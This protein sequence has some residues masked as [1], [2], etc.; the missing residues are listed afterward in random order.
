MNDGVERARAIGLDILQPSATELQ[1]GLELHEEALVFESYGFSPRAAIDGAAV[2]RLVEEGASDRELGE[3]MEE[4]GLLR[5]TEDAHLRDEYAR[6]FA[7]AGVDCV[8][9]NAGEECQSAAQLLKR[10]GNFTYLTDMLGDVMMRVPTP[11]A[12]VEA[13]RAGKRSLYMS[14]NGVPLAQEWKTAE[15][16]LRFVRV[17]FQLGVRMMHLTYNRRNMLGDGCAE[18][19]DAGLSDLGRAAIA[20]MNR[21]GVIVDVAHSGWQTCIDAAE[22]SRLPIVSSHAGVHALSGHVRCKT[23]AVMR[24]IVDKGGTLGICCVPAFLGGSGDIN[25]FLD[26]IDYVAKKFGVDAVTIGT[27]RA[28]VPPIANEEWAKV[29]KL[30]RKR[31]RFEGFW[32]PNDPLFAAEW[33]EERMQQSLAWTNWPLFTV[34]LVQRG[35][36]D[37]DICKI[38]GGNI[39][40]VTKA[41]W[42]GRG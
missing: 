10:L 37:D 33:K 9:Q 15:E 41:V 26:H 35:Y 6:A 21:V 22:A 8:F 19:T 5:M 3:Q 12:I 20:E 14:A 42:D 32:P 31:A 36:S 18:K 13:K 24:A 16:E 7:Y 23:D 38:L 30:G 1:H 29:P 34:G 28:Y 4:M 2:A 11:G 25:A 17:F 39:L 40:R 27:D